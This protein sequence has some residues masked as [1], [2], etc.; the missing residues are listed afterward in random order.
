MRSD[1]IMQLKEQRKQLLAE[2]RALTSRQKD[3][4]A[5]SQE[6]K[7]RSDYL[8][9]EL[10]SIGET[11]EENHRRE[12]EEIR[13]ARA[14]N[15]GTLSEFKTAGFERSHAPEPLYQAFR[16]AGFARGEKAEVPWPEFY[17]ALSHEYRAITWTGSVDNL[18]S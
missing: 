2:A 4:E 11:L 6:D 5:W 7:Q 9:N 14:G 12:L 10:R 3:G 8:Y 13:S 1:E 16:S 18:D 17:R 15:G